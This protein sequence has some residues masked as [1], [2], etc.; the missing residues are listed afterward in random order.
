MTNVESTG[1]ILAEP[2]GI[3]PAT[4]QCHHGAIRLRTE[5]KTWLHQNYAD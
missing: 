5:S 3:H 2:D 1:G 4:L